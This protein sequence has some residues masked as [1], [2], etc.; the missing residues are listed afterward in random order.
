MAGAL[1]DVAEFVV[2]ERG[3][4]ADVHTADRVDDLL[5]AVEVHR[6][7]VVDVQPAHRGQRADQALRSAVGVHAVEFD[8]GGA[9]E[10][11]AVGTGVVVPLLAVGTVDLQVARKGHRDHTAAVG[12]DVDQ[13]DGVGTRALH[14]T[15]VTR[16]DARVVAAAG[17]GAD[18]QIGLV[19]V[20]SLFVADVRV[21]G[22]DGGDGPPRAVPVL[23]VSPDETGADQRGHARERHQD[24]PGDGGSAAHRV[25]LGSLLRVML[26]G[27]TRGD[28]RG[29]VGG[30]F[31]RRGRNRC[32]GRRGRGRRGSV[33]FL[34]AGFLEGALGGGRIGEVDAGRAGD[35]RDLLGCLDVR[36]GCGCRGVGRGDVEVVDRGGAFVGCG[37]PRFGRGGAA[38]GRRL[39]GIHL[40][41]ELAHGQP[42]AA[43]DIAVGRSRFPQARMGR[44][45]GCRRVT[46]GG[47]RLLAGFFGATEAFAE[48][49]GVP[50]TPGAPATTGTFVPGTGLR[51]VR[52]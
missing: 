25:T 42:C 14:L 50:V 27:G 37:L 18:D 31:Q 29:Q 40:L 7:E 4:G 15:G 5:E 20:L 45:I 3:G 32:R 22:V 8:P 34:R 46:R 52:S 23:E 49:V 10:G 2:V 39:L 41:H 19:A 33:A 24:P 28:P 47:G 6:D 26:G 16:T 44:R 13:D 17:V 1:E 51:T 35:R 12:R 9:V 38:S 43:A 11:V 36:G 21:V 48:V 30:G